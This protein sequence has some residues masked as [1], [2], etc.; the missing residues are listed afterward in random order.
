MVGFGEAIKRGFAGWLT[1]S[2]RATRA[3]YWWWTLFAALLTLIPY[4]GFVATMDWSTKSGDGSVQASGSGGNI[5]FLVLAGIAVLVV[6]LP[7]IAVSVRRLHD[8]DRSG[9]WYWIQ[10]IPCGIGAIWFL[11][12]MVLPSS[13]PQNRYG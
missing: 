13:S 1:W 8:T 7:S 5:L 4:I 2:G 3:E 6:I 12:L 11:V 9:W 10:L